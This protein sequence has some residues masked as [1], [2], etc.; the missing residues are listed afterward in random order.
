MRKDSFKW[1]LTFNIARNWNR[2]E[3]SYNGVDFQTY[4]DAGYFDSNVSIIGK[5]LNGLYVY[6]DKG[7][8]NSD[9]EVPFIFENGQKIYLQL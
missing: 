2:L 5:P 4:G 3:K 8:Y 7:Y 6:K 1:D 9:D